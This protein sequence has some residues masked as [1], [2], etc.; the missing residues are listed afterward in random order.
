MNRG[1]KMEMNRQIVEW[2]RHHDMS[3]YWLLDLY[4][5]LTTQG[6]TSEDALTA[7]SLFVDRAIA[8]KARRETV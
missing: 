5:H 4:R 1:P 3:E 8:R 6:A 7:M 2:I